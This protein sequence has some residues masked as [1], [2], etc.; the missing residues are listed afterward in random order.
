[1]S[2][3]SSILL[4]L[5]WNLDD[6]DSPLGKDWLR[7]FYGEISSTMGYSRESDEISRDELSFLINEKFAKPF[8]EAFNDLC[9]RFRGKNSI[10][11]GAGPSLEND[12]MGLYPVARKA[13]N[14]IIAADGAADLLLNANIVPHITV[15]DLDSCSEQTLVSLS[16]ERSLFV[17]AHGDN[18][19]L[20]KELVPK[21]GSNLLGTTQVSSIKKV[22]NLGGFMDGDRACYLATYFE[23]QMIVFAGM[24]FQ[25]LPQ[26]NEF[27]RRSLD[28]NQGSEEIQTRK[29]KF[30]FGKYSLE[31]LIQKKTGIR[32]VNS[33]SSDLRI[34]GVE[35]LDTS[36]IIE[37]LS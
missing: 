6:Y 19:N 21:M 22:R 5:D 23:P 37:E 16:K 20:L 2:L 8:D 28:K 15:S 13:K 10:V 24:D 32:F 17:H 9:L 34:H 12:I 35:N 1:M 7:T 11:F 33:T 14:L 18:T 3:L 31:F 29:K 25:Y 27:Q 36:K 4:L 30:N 26:T